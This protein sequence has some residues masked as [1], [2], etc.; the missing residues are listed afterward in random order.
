MECP[1]CGIPMNSVTARAHPGALIQLDQCQQCGGIW[2]DKWELFPIDPDEAE[3][4]DS[5]D[6]A[7]LTAQTKRPPRPLYCPRCTGRLQA[8][9]DPALPADILLERCWRC[10][11]IWLNRGELKRYKRHQRKVR[12]EKMGPEAILRK[13][14]EVYQDPKAWVVL[15]TQGMMAYPRNPDNPS[16]EPRTTLGGAFRMILQTLLRMA[17][18]I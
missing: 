3:R 8:C 6:E 5:L 16:V 14:P 11:G 2:C 17:M 10:E 9:K 13:I 15:G 1:Q 18:G 12:M 7:R 4:L